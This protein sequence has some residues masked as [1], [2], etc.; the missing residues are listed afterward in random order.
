[1]FSPPVHAPKPASRACRHIRRSAPQTTAS[2]QPL[3]KVRNFR[4]LDANSRAS[5][6]PG[7][8]S[9]WPTATCE[10][11]AARIRWTPMQSGMPS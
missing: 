11:T 1:V 5:A 6:S 10:S 2:P 3:S 8:S 9:C 4:S 7:R